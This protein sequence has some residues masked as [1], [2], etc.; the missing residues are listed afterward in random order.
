MTDGTP[1]PTRTSQP[2]TLAIDVGGS[3]VKASVLDRRGR[4]LHERARV[5]TPKRLT[6][7][8]LV[9]IAAQLASHLPPFDRISVGFPGVVRNGV[10]LTAPNLGTPRFKGFNLEQA[11]TR[12]LRKPARVCND[13]DVQG[14]AAIKGK[15]VEV[16]ITL[17]TGFGSSIFM[18]GR[19]GPHL[20]LAHHCFR[21]GCTYEEELG[22]AAFKSH[23]K[24]KWNKRLKLAI[25][26]LRNLTWF[27]HLYIG[28]GNARHINFTLPS[29]VSVVD[30]VAGIIGGVRLWE[31]EAE[32][33][34]KPPRKQPAGG[35]MPTRPSPA[36]AAE[37]PAL[38]RASES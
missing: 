15:G 13:A 37:T 34:A 14:F 36:P 9:T 5:D 17:G 19:L 29:N 33:K 31:S 7:A 2:H 26:T 1:A 30:N 35:A 22:D 8:K 21:N 20:E 38:A 4:L 12:R 11:L 16:V 25:E 28:G 18:D 27:D 3:H 32:P 24:R 6:P 23:G 10:I